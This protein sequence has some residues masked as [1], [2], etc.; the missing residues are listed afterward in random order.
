MSAKAY[1]A[2]FLSVLVTLTLDGRFHSSSDDYQG[3]TFDDAYRELQRMHR[4][5]LHRLSRYGR[6]NDDFWGIRCTEVH[7]DGC[8][9]FHTVLYIRPELLSVVDAAV[10]ALY[11]EQSR[12]AKAYFECYKDQ[13]IKVRQAKDAKD[14]GE[15]ISYIFKNSYSARSSD[16]ADLINSLRQKAVISLFDKNQYELIGGNGTSAMARQLRKH[17]ALSETL[18]ALCIKPGAGGQRADRLEITR[19]LIDDGLSKFKIIRGDRRNKYGELIGCVVGVEVLTE[20]TSQA[21]VTPLEYVAVIYNYTR[22]LSQSNSEVET[23]SDAVYILGNGIRGPPI[24]TLNSCSERFLKSW[25]CCAKGLNPNFSS[26]T[27]I[28]RSSPCIFASAI[29]S[30]GFLLLS[31]C[32]IIFNLSSVFVRAFSLR[33]SK[34]SL[35]MSADSFFSNALALLERPLLCISAIFTDDVAAAVACSASIQF[36][37]L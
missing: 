13:V 17:Q 20:L 15:A 12:A 18:D 25:A 6:R 23:V 5:L 22:M 11:S 1:G 2:G 27:P 14:H 31:S 33:K 4:R 32:S 9:H 36:L 29:S 28:I 26:S 19:A 37:V 16:R 30:S 7:R 24:A 34:V 3:K 35:Y 21:A 8:P 10:S